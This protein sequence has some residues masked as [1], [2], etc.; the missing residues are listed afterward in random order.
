VSA[1]DELWPKLRESKEYRDAF[2]A[3]YT[4][5]AI[6]AQV[7]ALLDQFGW[8]QSELAERAGIDQST[9]SR[10]ADYTYGKP[11]ISTCLSIAAGFDI[12]FIPMFVPFSELPDWLDRLAAFRVATFDVE[13]AEIEAG[14]ALEELRSEIIERVSTADMVVETGSDNWQ[15]IELKAQRFGQPDRAGPKRA[16][17]WPSDTGGEVIQWRPDDPTAR[18][19]AN[20]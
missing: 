17:R 13:N 5:Q 3:Q 19:T 2:V 20:G 12:A 11:S 15:V 9:V 10:V 8:S 18:S 1:F 16:R 4:R 14:R 6:A 7:K